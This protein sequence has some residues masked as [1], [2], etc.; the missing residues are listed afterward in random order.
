MNTSLVGRYWNFN[1]TCKTNFLA[2]F[3]LFLY[4][5][6]WKSRQTVLPDFDPP[7][8]AKACRVIKGAERKPTLQYS[9]ACHGCFLH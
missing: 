5:V 7:F 9:K 6:F 4:V 8:A 1:L 3:W 2:I